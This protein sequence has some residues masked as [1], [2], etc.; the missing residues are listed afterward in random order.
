MGAIACVIETRLESDEIAQLDELL[1]DPAHWPRTIWGI[2]RPA[3]LTPAARKWGAAEVGTNWLQEHGHPDITRNEVLRHYRLHVPIMV[4]TIGAFAIIAGNTAHGPIVPKGALAIMDFYRKGIELGSRTMALLEKKIDR[5]IEEEIPVPTD[6]LLDITDL[7]LKLST[8]A[9]T[10]AA[11]GSSPL[12]REEDVWE[13]AID[14]VGRPGPRIGHSRQ[15]VIDGVTRLVHD[16]GPKDRAEY[17]E[18]AAR[19][20]REKIG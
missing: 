2:L 14:G 6:L 16:E 17:N 18:R 7:G 10:L 9:A 8:S 1:A 13:G 11:R 4:T 15:R 19:E 3:N 20:G 12:G 5:M